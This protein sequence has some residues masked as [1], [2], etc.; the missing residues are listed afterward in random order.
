MKFW[1]PI[2]LTKSIENNQKAYNSLNRGH[3]HNTFAKEVSQNDQSKTNL[4]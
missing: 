3:P 4:P 2:L 1:S